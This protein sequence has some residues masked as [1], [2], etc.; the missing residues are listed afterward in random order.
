MSGVRVGTFN[1]RFLPHLPSNRRRATVLAR[2]IAQYDYDVIGLSEVFSGRA[3]SALVEGLA[4]RYPYNVQY[5]GSTKWFREDSGLMLFS[6]LPFD[7][8]PAPHPFAHTK[9]R[10]S[11]SGFTPDWPH[12][13]F[14]EYAECC[15]SDCLAG[16]GAAYARTRLDGRP[17]HIFF[18]HMQAKYDFHDEEMQRRTRSIRAA[19]LSQMK[20]LIQHALSEGKAATENVLILGDFN[21]DGMRSGAAMSRE[22]ESSQDEWSETLASLN[23]LFPRGVLDVWDCHAPLEDPGHTYSSRAPLARRDYVMLSSAD[24]DQPLCVHHVSLAHNLAGEEGADPD[25]PAMSDHF[26]INVDINRPAPACHPLI[27]GELTG[28]DGLPTIGGRIEHAGGLKWYKVDATG[29]LLIGRIGE[30]DA[31][32]E[33]FAACDISRPMRWKPVAGNTSSANGHLRSYAVAGPCYIRV[34]DPKGSAVGDYRFTIG[35]VDGNG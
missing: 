25:E 7:P 8:L 29:S 6:K 2:R 13:W 1:G 24:S 11:S 19:Q 34:G 9:L 31:G 10:A 5:I 27:A 33:V 26:G 16:K 4:E 14:V 18:T 21:V 22:P 28:L 15:S 35:H 17:L 30:F 23:D 3:R 12:V 32:V 20:R